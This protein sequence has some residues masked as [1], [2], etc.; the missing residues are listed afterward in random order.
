M[1]SCDKVASKYYCLYCGYN[2]SKSSSYNKH[3]LTAKHK[4]L[5]KGNESKQQV[6]KS[7]SEIKCEKCNKIYNSRVGL[8]KHKK[9]C[10]QKPLENTLTITDITNPSIIMNLIKENQEFKS[11]LIE[12]NKKQE[13]LINKVIEL[14][15]EPRIVNH[16][17]MT[18]NN[19][20]KFNLQVFLNDTCKDAITL[21]QFID[22]IHISLEDLENVGRNGYLKGIS[23]IFINKLNTLDITKRPIHCTDVKREVIYLKEEDTWNKDDKDNTKL[24]NAIRT[25][26]DKN[27]N[28]IPEWQRE[29]PDV[30]HSD[31]PEYKMREKIMRN[32]ADH[33]NVE[34]MREKV[35]KVLAKETHVDKSEDN[36]IM[37][38][39]TVKP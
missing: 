28:K 11:L 36:S 5:T 27:W 25:V 33:D 12:Q 16:G 24:K 30:I 21:Q 8:W 7:C 19:N 1:E 32:I 37:D 26:E 20:N 31:T 3:L 29:N 9:K 2:T 13:E 39:E 10:S 34:K 35:V 38:I 15:R 18:Q 23:D 17:T 22:N 6:S 14:S 4:K